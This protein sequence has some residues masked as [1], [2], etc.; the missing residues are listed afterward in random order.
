MLNWLK[1]HHIMHDTTVSMHKQVTLYS[2]KNDI[3]GLLRTVNSYA[4]TSN[5]V[6]AKNDIL[7][8]LRTVNSLQL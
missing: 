5:P 7:G 1:F 2:Q 6:L 4:Q 8:L 3:L